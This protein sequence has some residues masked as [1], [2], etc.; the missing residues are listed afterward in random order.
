MYNSE[1]RALFHPTMNPWSPNHT[2][3]TKSWFH[4]VPE[5][6]WLYFPIVALQFLN[7]IYSNYIFLTFAFA[8]VSHTLSCGFGLHNS[9]CEGRGRA[10]AHLIQLTGWI[11]CVGSQNAL[12]CRPAQVEND[13]HSWNPTEIDYIHLTG[14]LCL[15][16]VTACRPAW[17]F[18]V[19][20]NLLIMTGIWNLVI[21]R[22]ISK[23]E[24]T[25]LTNGRH[26]PHLT[27][28]KWNV[29]LPALSLMFVA[30][31]FLLYLCIQ[32]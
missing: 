13:S 32:S 31:P 7:V 6:D 29:P 10:A 20:Y 12:D 30:L 27:S 19:I 18:L 3:D 21:W 24:K 17:V 5:K 23:L 26:V 11:M 15:S 25:H 8:L 2:V 14:S 22:N 16:P 28:R 1:S 4:S 9:Q